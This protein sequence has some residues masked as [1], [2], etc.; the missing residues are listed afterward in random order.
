MK[1]Q[2]NEGELDGVRIL[3]PQTIELMH[4]RTIPLRGF[5][6]PSMELYGMGLG[7]QLWG[8]GL[9]GHGGAVTAFYAQML[10]KPDGE[11]SHGVILI[12]NTGCSLVECDFEWYDTF[13]VVIREL[14]LQEG[15][16]RLHES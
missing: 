7:W 9:Q 14:L 13:I 11:G 1:M 15:A 12:M 4:E 5:D 2:M 16:A 3:E 10:G 8:D 6:F